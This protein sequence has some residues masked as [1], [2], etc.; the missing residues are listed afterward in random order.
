[1]A[2]HTV[3]MN[4]RAF[5]LAISTIVI[6]VIG[7][8]VLIGLVYALTGGF[9]RFQDTTA[10]FTD[11]TQVTAIKSGCSAACQNADRYTFCCQEYD[12][13]GNDVTCTD[14]R[15]EVT[16]SLDCSSFSCRNTIEAEECIGQEGQIVP[17]TGDGQVVENKDCPDGKRYVADVANY[18]E[19]AICCK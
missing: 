12:L 13:D 7:V 4:R 17:D 8:L 18:L 10:P 16:C 19:G 15:L 14:S 3:K 2:A 1:M 11:S 5:E 6:L 9:E